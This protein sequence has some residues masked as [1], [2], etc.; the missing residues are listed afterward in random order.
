MQK[1][2]C[3]YLLSIEHNAQTWQTD[4]QTDHGTVMSIAIGDWQWQCLQCCHHQWHWEMS[5]VWQSPTWPRRCRAVNVVIISSWQWM[6]AAAWWCLDV[7][8]W[9]NRSSPTLV[10]YVNLPCSLVSF[11]CCYKPPATTAVHHWDTELSI[12]LVIWKEHLVN[13]AQQTLINDNTEHL[14]RASC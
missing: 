5:S 4:R 14:N 12:K 8:K 10:T 13:L 9:C 2:L 3:R 7:S 6:S 1:K 11:R